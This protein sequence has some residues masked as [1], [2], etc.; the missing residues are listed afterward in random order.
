MAERLE[1]LKR[2]NRERQQ[3]FRARRQNTAHS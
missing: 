1:H 2:L 3:R